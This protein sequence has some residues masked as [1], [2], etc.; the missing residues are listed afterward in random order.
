MLP[1]LASMQFVGT[2]DW[3]VGHAGVLES[4]DAGQTWDVVRV[5]VREPSLVDFVD[6]QHGWIAGADALWGT[7]DGGRSWRRSAQI[8][9]CAV[10]ESV[11]FVS[12]GTGFAVTRERGADPVRGRSLLSTTTDGGRTWH[13]LMTPTGAQSVCFQDSRTGWLGGSYGLYVTTDGGRVWESLRQ[14][15]SGTSFPPLLTVQ[16]GGR[17]L[18][19]AL[20]AGPGGASSQ[21]PHI[22]Y[23]LTVTSA[24]PLFAEQYFPHPGVKV[25]AWSAGSYAGPYSSVAGAAVFVDWCP[26]C[27][28]GTAPWLVA[29][30]A[31][32]GLQRKGDVGHLTR[33]TAASFTSVMRG[34][35]AGENYH[36]E[37]NT[38]LA[39]IV[40][41]A[42]GGAHWSLRWEAPAR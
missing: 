36:W 22:G 28:R 42:D 2:T 11:H 4:T 37:T 5:G 20:T 33:P 13:R 6:S 29:G 3:A 34:C 21:S 16:C 9:R 14:H 25:H 18:A 19:W 1:A 30:Q 35:V 17:G 39:R 41:T 23:R 32:N 40:C 31:G 12:P 38:L 15:P 26:S 10:V 7:V 24:T 27:G 8:A